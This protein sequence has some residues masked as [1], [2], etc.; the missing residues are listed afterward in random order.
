MGTK[1]TNSYRE[2]IQ[3]FQEKADKSNRNSMILIVVSA[4]IT[5]INIFLILLRVL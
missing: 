2:Y 3:A 4:V 1:E 5:A